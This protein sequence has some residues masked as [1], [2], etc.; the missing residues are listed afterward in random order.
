[1][2]RPGILIGVD[3]MQHP[4]T[5]WKVALVSGFSGV[6]N[7]GEARHVMLVHNANI[8]KNNFEAWSMGDAH[9][10]GAI[11]GLS[12]RSGFDTLL[13]SITSVFQIL[14]GSGWPEVMKMAIEATNQTSVIYFYSLLFVGSIVLFNLFV[15]VIIVAFNRQLEPKSTLERLDR[16]PFLE[17]KHAPGVQKRKR[18]LYGRLYNGIYYLVGACYRGLFP[19]IMNRKFEQPRATNS[20]TVPQPASSTAEASGPVNAAAAAPVTHM[21]PI[22]SSKKKQ[23]AKADKGDLTSS[24]FKNAHLKPKIESKGLAWIGKELWKRKMDVI[25]EDDQRR[26]QDEERERRRNWRFRPRSMMMDKFAERLPP[27]HRR[28]WVDERAG[29]NEW[30]RGIIV[31]YS[32]EEGFKVVYT[33]ESLIW[34]LMCC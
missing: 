14:G 15:A 31:E 30:V 13:Q 34:L 11:M 10:D 23:L 12:P 9:G 20:V 27:G 29:P 25:E 16:M 19:L 5:P 4:L 7:T 26:F 28:K 3:G 21:K 24:E 6:V 17:L 32:L 1:M 2:D 22:K 33:T 18:G 8:D